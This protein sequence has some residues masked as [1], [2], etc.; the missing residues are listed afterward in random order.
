MNEKVVKLY[1]DQEENLEQIMEETN[2]MRA[3]YD[4]KIEAFGKDINY[5]SNSVSFLIY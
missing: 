1:R 3:E 5:I 2:L 4:G